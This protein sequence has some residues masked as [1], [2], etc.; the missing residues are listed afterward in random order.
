MQQ[1]IHGLY[2]IADTSVLMPENLVSHVDAALQGGATIIQYRDKSENRTLRRQQ[3]EKLAM[4]CEQHKALLVINDDLELAAMLG[5]G[6]HVGR[7]DL[8]LSQAR[9]QLG[10][11]TV[12]GT[13]CYNQLDLAVHAQQHGASYVAFGRFF[14]SQTKPEAV[15]AEPDLLRAAK[16][17]LTVPIVAIGGINADNAPILINAGADAVAVINDIFGGDH[18]RTAAARYQTLFT[19]SI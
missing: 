9:Q 12:I 13:S 4:L 6:L 5:A 11:D 8:A 16:R 3:A 15:Q 1:S 2:A 10:N 7:H 18:P 14:P 19:H 17:V